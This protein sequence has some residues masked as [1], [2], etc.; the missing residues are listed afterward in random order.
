[1]LCFSTFVS[2]PW[3]I[4]RRVYLNK[5][6]W[7]THFLLPRRAR[8]ICFYVLSKCAV[9][10]GDA[11]G[12]EALNQAFIQGDRERCVLLFFWLWSKEAPYWGGKKNRKK[13]W[14]CITSACITSVVQQVLCSAKDFL[15]STYIILQS[16]VTWVFH[17]SLISI[18]VLFHALKMHHPSKKKKN[19]LEIIILLIRSTL[20]STIYL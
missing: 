4:G 18:S 19:F 3:F 13:E 6:K 1:M 8:I 9:E 14:S 11:L 5:N 16:G 12:G 20:W 17:M 2:F 15:S 10:V 7:K